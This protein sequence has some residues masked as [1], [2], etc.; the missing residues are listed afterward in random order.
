M[1]NKAALVDQIKG[2]QRS[3][4]ETKQAWWD[5]CDEEL[6]GVRD[7]NKHDVGV[8]NHFLSSIG[9]QP[10]RGG[11]GGGGGSRGAGG[12]PHANQ[13]FG[14]NYMPTPLYSPPVFNGAWGGGYPANAGYMGGGM[15]APMNE[16]GDFIKMGQRKSKPWKAA[17]QAYCAMYGS[18]L[19]D[20]MKYDSQFIVGFL[21]YLGSLGEADLGAAAEV[22]NDAPVAIQPAPAPAQMQAQ[23]VSRKRAVPPGIVDFGSAPKKAA[24]SSGPVDNSDAEKSELVERVKALQRRDTETKQAWWQ[25]TDE[26]HGGIHDPNRHGKEVLIKFLDDYE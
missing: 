15:V 11:G 22:Q 20:P 1:A 6:A 2:L 12:P 19:N 13:G 23:P 17:W 25:Y 16:L 5:Y 7:P 10:A 21:D 9:V 3:D 4:P 24:T 18:G 8:L 26:Q 14:Y